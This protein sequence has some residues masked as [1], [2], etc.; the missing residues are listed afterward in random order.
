MGRILTAGLGGK[1]PLLVAANHDGSTDL[2]STAVRLFH[3][4]FMLA[5][6]ISAGRDM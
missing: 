6:R 2:G 5:I 4:L 3:H 1:L